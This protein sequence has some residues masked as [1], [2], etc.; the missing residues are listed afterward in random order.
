[1]IFS[2]I[3]RTVAGVV[4]AAASQ[5][6]SLESK[7]Q[8]RSRLNGPWP[9][10]PY[11]WLHGASLGECRMLLN[12]AKFLKEDLT[13]CPRI[14]ITT[15]KTEVLQFLE[16][17]DTDIDFSIAPADTPLALSLFFSSVKPIALVLAENE[18]WPGY[19]STMRKLSLN[20]SI[21]LISGRFRR[22]LFPSLL[23]SIGFASM[24]TGSDLRRLLMASENQIQKSFIGGD[25]KLLSWARSGETLSPP[26]NPA[27]DT[28]FISMH[29]SEWTSLSKMIL[30]SVKRQE[31]VVLIPRRLEELPKFREA[32]RDHELLIIDW[33]LV[34]KGAVSLVTEFGRSQEV[35]RKSR[36]AVVGGSFAWGLGV[37]D[38]WE[39]LQCGVS[40]FVGPYAKG[41]E[42]TVE[43]LL[44]EGVLT[45]FQS[46]ADYS[47]RNPPDFNLT[48]T[49]LLHERE[50]VLESFQ[51]FL[52]FLKQVLVKQ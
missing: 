38:F 23:S 17:L 24:Q 12:V 52:D 41:Q 6:P 27:V 39:P 25:W 9:T 30:N 13:N 50:K 8:L 28:T 48:K 19:L 42:D 2:D 29:F 18:L 49:F 40:T 31:S 44:R 36:S 14:L 45:R 21:A 5:I 35:L 4:G 22:T 32:L 7:F 37:H 10:G 47:F 26:D 46:P 20:S 43:A 1:M 3:A 16:S 15:Q 33:P 51:S 11:L 34:Q